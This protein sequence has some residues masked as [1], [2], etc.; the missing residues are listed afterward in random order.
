MIAPWEWLRR[1]LLRESEWRDEL[2]THLAMREECNRAQG[3]SGDAARLAAQRQ[4]GNRLR[5]LEDVR[6]VHVRRWLEDLLQDARLA[7]R[8]FRKSPA[9]AA[10]AVATIALGVGASAAIFGVVDPLLFRPLPYPNGHQLVS[11]GY[12][13]SVDSNE[14]SVVSS[15]LDWRQRQTAFQAMT[16][17]R[18]ESKC[19]LLA[20]DAPLQID[21]QQ[22]EANFLR[23]LG[24]APAA[25]RDFTSDDDQPHAPP[26]ALLSYALWQSRYG[27][28]AR[29]LGQTVTVD[30]QPVKVAG[31]LPKGFE[32]PQLGRADLMMPERLDAS[33]PRAANSSAF[34]RTFARLREGV[35]IEEARLR[36]IPLFQQ[37]AQ[38]DVPRELRSEGRLVVRSLRERQIHDVKLASWMLFGAVLALLLLVCANVANLLLAR[39]AARRRELAVR[40]AIGAGRG[41]LVRQMLTESL[42]LALAGGLAGCG[43]AWALVRALVAMAPGGLLR[44]GRT[45]MD[46]RVLLFALAASLAAA[47]LCGLAPALERPRAEALTGARVAGTARTLFRRLLVAAQVAISLVLLTGASLFWRSF[48]K[49][50]SQPLGFRTER[51]MTASFTLR[52][53]RYLPQ[54]ARSAAFHELESRLQAIPGG[55]RFALSDSIPPRGSMGRPFSNL[56]IAGHPPVAADGGMV[57]FRWVTPGYFRVMNIPILAGRGFE[58]GERASGESPLVLSATLAR[59][60]FGNE[61]P[62]GQQLDLTADGH[63]CTIV[64]VAADTRN[65]GLTETHPEYYRL[66]M[67]NRAPPR[68]AVALFR[69][70]I[71]PSELARW[72]R[73][74]VAD[75]DR[76]L[77]VTI[78]T[79]E[80][81]L[82]RFR[83][84]PRFLAALVALFAAF[85]LL[86]AAVGLY[87]VLSFLVAQRTQEIGVRMALGARPLDIALLVG[88]YAGVWT[89]IGAAAGVACSIG[90]ARM[91]KGLLFGVAPEDL[92]SLMTAVV[93]LALTAAVAAWA[94]S[95]RAARVDPTVALRYE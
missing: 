93:V 66:R 85:G 91:A 86:L 20:G 4:F 16:S 82:G 44:T 7:V 48:W 10:A 25:G 95:R 74:K 88:A 41:R 77:P 67:D 45:G 40:A 14:F 21:C 54:Q 79:M 46:A 84:Q 56:R 33:R 39:S 64:G 5:T 76:A 2:D 90:I 51:V 71:A 57:Y 58:E 34:L 15:Y 47:L 29:V 72:I 81:R 35:S 9:L 55:G 52:Q 62:V 19:D 63:W 61:S 89:G 1:R 3:L 92:G 23:T 87:G 18:P 31:I 26:V 22:V 83:E 13:G 30:E 27:G 69:S 68:E 73:A 49:L 11:L 50:A 17:M 78:E 94:P 12:L 36:M 59:R 32:M 24:L 28:D 75:V 42:V 53:Q 70:S 65:N 8:G 43:M 6:A 38:L 37:T 60:L 80:D